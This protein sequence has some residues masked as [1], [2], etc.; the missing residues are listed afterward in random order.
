M[1]QAN[2]RPPAISP[3]KLTDLRKPFG[4][5]CDINRQDLDTQYN[6]RNPPFEST[7]PETPLNSNCPDIKIRIQ[8][9]AKPPAR[10]PRGGIFR[11]NVDVKKAA[12]YGRSKKGRGPLKWFLEEEIQVARDLLAREKR[13]KRT[14]EMQKKIVMNKMKEKSKQKI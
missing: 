5:C 2:K 1:V 11:D 10:G 12:V 6:L 13:I 3:T 9:I 8:D 4:F 7:F 14:E